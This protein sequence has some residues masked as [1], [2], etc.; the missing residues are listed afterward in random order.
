MKD[1]PRSLW[2][3]LCANHH[4]VAQ[5]I[6]WTKIFRHIWSSLDR[7]ITN[8]PAIEQKS[9][10]L[11][12]KKAILNLFYLNYHNN[13]RW[14]A[15][16]VQLVLNLNIVH[17]V[18]DGGLDWKWWDQVRPGSGF[19]VPKVSIQKIRPDPCSC[20]HSKSHHWSLLLCQWVN[21]ISIFVLSVFFLE[22]NLLIYFSCIY[23]IVG[24]CHIFSA[25]LKKDNC[26]RCLL[27]INHWPV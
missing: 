8:T 18:K 9:K 21:F 13:N 26:V 17:R 12:E 7:Y 3:F 14:C 4:L 2:R 20:G 24:V 25:K 15:D 6:T 11:I 10:Q 23:S 1:L 19:E 27:F 16:D 22:T 5:A